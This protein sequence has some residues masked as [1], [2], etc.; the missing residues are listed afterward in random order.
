MEV[1]L[2]EA[3]TGHFLSG[4]RIDAVPREQRRRQSIIDHLT[5]LLNTRRGSIGHLPNYGLPDISSVYRD[6]PQSVQILKRAMREIIEAYEPRLMKPVRVEEEEQERHSGDFILTFLITAEIV[7]GGS[8]R[9]Q[10]R[11]KNSGV[12]EI[13]PLGSRPS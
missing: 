1:G 11:F 5:F 10:T 8:V 4:E 2:F 13:Q 6:M 12:A 9:F 7:D 3:L